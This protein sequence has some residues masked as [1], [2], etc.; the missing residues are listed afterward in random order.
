MYFGGLWGGQL[1]NW[2]SRQ[3]DPAGREPEGS[4]PALGPRVA[5]LNDDMKTL[6]GDI[7][8]ISILDEQGRPLRASDHDRRFFEAA[9]M[10]KRGGL[11]YF[12]YSTGDTHYL[13]YATGTD[14]RG[15]FTYRG[16]IMEP[17]IG[18][19]THHSIVEFNK[20]WF[21]FHHD[22]SLSGGVNHLRCVKVRELTHDD[23]GALRLAP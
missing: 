19:T 6:K 23:E 11:Y 12:S 4:A 3:Y 2:S 10:H 5:A 21:L 9:W 1:Q 15:P 7:Q 8:E 16:R 17:V 20:R 14:P 13:V 22:A 18:W